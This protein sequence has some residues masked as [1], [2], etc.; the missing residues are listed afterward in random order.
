[1][2][3]LKEMSNSA[4]Q[5]TYNQFKVRELNWSRFGAVYGVTLP[6]PIGQPLLGVKLTI[7]YH[8]SE[9]PITVSGPCIILRSGMDLAQL[10]KEIENYSIEQL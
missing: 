9:A 7:Q 4:P 3:L 10:K 5:Q 1:M 8:A 2:F 6:K